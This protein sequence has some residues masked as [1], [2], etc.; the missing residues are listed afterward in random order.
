LDTREIKALL[1]AV[2]IS[3]MVVVMICTDVMEAAVAM[4]GLS[5]SSV[6]YRNK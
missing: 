1:V 6:L 5:S 4:P 3:V 2:A